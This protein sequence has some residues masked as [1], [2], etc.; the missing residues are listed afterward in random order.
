MTYFDLIMFWLPARHYADSAFN[1][2][3]IM[4]HLY[5]EGYIWAG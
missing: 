1:R 2:G 5:E 4:E 3:F